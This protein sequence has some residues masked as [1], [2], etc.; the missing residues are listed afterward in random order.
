MALQRT[1][2]GR[3]SGQHSYS[4]E[5]AEPFAIRTLRQTFLAYGAKEQARIRADV[6]ARL[7]YEAQRGQR[8]KSALA[9]LARAVYGIKSEDL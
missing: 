4:R 1:T 7:R 8:Q 2:E 5:A 6:I 9:R 3:M